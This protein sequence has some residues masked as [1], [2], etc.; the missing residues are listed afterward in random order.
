MALAVSTWGRVEVDI[1]K[2]QVSGISLEIEVQG[3]PA[4]HVFLTQD[5]HVQRRGSGRLGDAQADLFIGHVKEPLFANVLAAMQD[6]I[7]AYVGRRLDA[8]QPVGL[9]CNLELTF[10]VGDSA[11]SLELGYGQASGLPP[12][13]RALV[14]AMVETTQP[15]YEGQ[16]RNVNQGKKKRWFWPFG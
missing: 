3:I 6:N 7:L 1:T 5:G 12:E 16:R 4:L 15:W 13:V 14:E 8:P 11:H 2:A 9:P 10:K